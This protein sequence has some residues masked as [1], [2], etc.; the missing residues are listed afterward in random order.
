[1]MYIAAVA[2]FVV[3]SVASMLDFQRCFILSNGV[4][5]LNI[6]L[7]FGLLILYLP[8]GSLPELFNIYRKLRFSIML[9]LG[10]IIGAY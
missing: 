7:V 3:F 10:G 2:W 1:M 5:S 8:C 9:G 6:S 4:I